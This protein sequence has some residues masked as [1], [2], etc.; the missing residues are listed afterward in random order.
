MSAPGGHF[1]SG[2]MNQSFP[3]LPAP[4]PLTPHDALFLDF[5]GT[6]VELAPTPQSVVVSP[7]LGSL[8]RNMSRRLQGAV[9]IVSG[10]PTRDIRGFLPTVSATV[11]GVHG[12]EIWRPDGS[13][14]TVAIAA[15]VLQA[16][17]AR[18]AAAT[19]EKEGVLLEDKQ[20]G[21]ALHYRAV[22]DAET[23]CHAAVEAA[24]AA[25]GGTL[26]AR[27]GNMVID[28]CPASVDK[29][30]AIRSLLGVPPFAGRNPVF[31]GDDYTDEPGFA[32]A[33]AAGGYGVLVGPARMTAANARLPSV[34]TVA[35]WL[36]RFANE[37]AS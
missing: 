36:A 4:P 34:A 17:R 26:R 13:R 37:Q 6:L 31:V 16:A 11:V 2:T 35:D 33:A 9:A 22:P 25:S 15:D 8:F 12:A 5:D 28:L 21:Y 30:T 3:E 29:G 32:A 10:R 27:P 18:L 24:A 19:E 7:T 1:D 20:L 23:L 14:E